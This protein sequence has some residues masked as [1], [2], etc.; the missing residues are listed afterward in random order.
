MVKNTLTAEL[1]HTPPT[2]AALLDFLKPFGITPPMC[3]FHPSAFPPLFTKCGHHMCHMHK[4]CT[5]N[6][7]IYGNL[8]L[9][10]YLSRTP[11][12][13]RPVRQEEKEMPAAGRASA[14][15]CQTR[16]RGAATASASEAAPSTPDR[17]VADEDAGSREDEVAAPTTNACT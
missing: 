13:P 8:D 9:K 4:V 1:K 2:I 10:A 16:A 14:R 15:P 7:E 5:M 3:P 12:T 6:D 17:E 11:Q